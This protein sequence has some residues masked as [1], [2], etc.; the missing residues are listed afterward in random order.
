LASLIT[1]CLKRDKNSGFLANLSTSTKKDLLF[2]M[3]RPEFKYNELVTYWKNELLI[4]SQTVQE[5]IDE[6]QGIKASK[7][8]QNIMQLLNIGTS[9][10]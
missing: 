1:A 4:T 3:A 8:K 7:P 6:Y 9:L 5:I 10:S 2:V